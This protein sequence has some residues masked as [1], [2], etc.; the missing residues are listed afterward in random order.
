MRPQ[1]LYL[2]GLQD[3]PPAASKWPDIIFDMRIEIL[4]LIN[5]QLDIHEGILEYDIC[6]W[7]ASRI[8]L[9]RPPGRF[10]FASNWLQ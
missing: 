2:A 3:Q 4:T 1:Y 5:L 8:S 6:T 10:K 7:L 9:Q